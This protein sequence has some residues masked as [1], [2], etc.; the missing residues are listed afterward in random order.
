M[1]FCQENEMGSPRWIA[2]HLLAR[3]N[4]PV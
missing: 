1:N 4:G 2:W 3:G